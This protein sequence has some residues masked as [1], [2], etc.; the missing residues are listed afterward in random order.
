MAH[1]KTRN[2]IG[3][4]LR[5]KL[6]CTEFA[7]TN[8]C[9]AKC[10]FCNIWKQKPKVFVDREKALTAIDRL[11]DFGVSHITLTGGE[12]LLHPHIMDFVARATKRRVNNAV[13]L[14]APALLLRKEAPRR[15]E[16]AGCD[17]VSIS[18]DSGDPATMAAS[19]QIEG[20]MD[21]MKRAMES[22]KRTALKTMASV[23]IWNENHDK[24]EEVCREARDMGFD[25]I[26][27]NY[28]TFSESKVYELG[29]EGISLPR[30]K[31][32]EAME[33][34][35]RL[36]QS[37]KYRIINSPL[38]MRNIIN[39]LKDPATVRHPCYGGTRVLF[40]DWFFD[41]HP[42]M[43]LPQVLGN[44]LTMQE[45]DLRRPACNDCNMSWYRDFSM[46][47]GGP[48]SIPALWEAVTGNRGLI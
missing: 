25:F 16:E 24:M 48:R 46:L 42:C 27:L 10:T 26:S 34:A 17:L 21:Q 43:Q 40:V 15:L 47:H 32:I 13:L 38:S 4:Y 3:N 44:I 29:G 30:L 12:P 9:I 18:F 7:L 2:I 14:A 37:K 35:I 19:R 23:L 8:A 41:V 45:N 31:V 5:G 20:I 33:A 11:A 22:V 28:P 1:G 36:I 39:Y 6:R